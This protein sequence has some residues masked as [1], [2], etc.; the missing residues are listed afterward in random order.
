MTGPADFGTPSSDAE[1]QVAV[2]LGI[3]TYTDPQPS[4]D[5]I[6]ELLQHSQIF[7]FRFWRS[8]LFVF[9]PEFLQLIA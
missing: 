2:L 1:R 4:E 7:R 9:L 6:S 3:E 5:Q 8:L